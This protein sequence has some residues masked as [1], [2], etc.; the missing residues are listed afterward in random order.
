[1]HH[2]QPI[3]PIQDPLSPGGTRNDLA[4]VLHRHPVTLQPQFGDNVLKAGRLRKRSKR[5]GLAI[6]NKRKRHN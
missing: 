3:P 2:F 4:I 1:V 5:T 6:K